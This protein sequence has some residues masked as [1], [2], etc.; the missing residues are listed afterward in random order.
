MQ[1]ILSV[2]KEVIHIE[3]DLPSA[4]CKDTVVSVLYG[5]KELCVLYALISTHLKQ[6][7]ARSVCTY[8]MATVHSIS[9]AGTR[10]HTAAPALT[11]PPP[12]YNYVC[13]IQKL[14]G[15]ATI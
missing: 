8:W 1:W 9:S 2:T 4:I 15:E 5:E 6:P 12:Q 11:P 10:V 7:A 13:I 14:S 3:G